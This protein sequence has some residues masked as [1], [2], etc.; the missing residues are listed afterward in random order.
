VSLIK[1]SEDRYLVGLCLKTIVRLGIV[2]SS[3]EDFL[4]AVNLI[5]QN[6]ELASHVDLRPEIKSLP[7]KGA[8]V[9]SQT[10][11]EGQIAVSIKETKGILK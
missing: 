11:A 3:A 4:I 6:P 5:N 2:R 1:N 7:L 9:S 8:A 10:S